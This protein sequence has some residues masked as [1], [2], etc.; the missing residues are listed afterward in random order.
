MSEHPVSL[1]GEPK[2]DVEQA[3]TFGLAL[4]EYQKIQ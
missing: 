2:V 3:R 1:A 4:D